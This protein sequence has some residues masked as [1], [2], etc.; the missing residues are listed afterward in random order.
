[1]TVRASAARVRDRFS[2]PE[3]NAVNDFFLPENT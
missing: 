3:G 2:A 1:M